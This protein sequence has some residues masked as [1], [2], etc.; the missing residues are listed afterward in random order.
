M[1]AKEKQIHILFIDDELN[2]QNAFF[3]GFR[4]RFKVYTASSAAEG[5]EVLEKEKIH[6]I[7]ADQRMPQFTGV[8]FFQKV[9]RSHPHP[10]RILL[11][12]Y[13]DIEALEDA[14]NKGEIYRY[15]KKPWDDKEVDQAI[16]NAYEIYFTREQL[17]IKITEL[18]KTN[19]EL[20]R[21][22]YSTSHDLRSPL[23]SIMGVL[24][25]AKMENSVKD[26]NGYMEMIG[27]CAVKMD[28]YIKKIIEYYR[29]VR[30][31]EANDSID[32]KK[33]IQENIQLH[34]MQ[35][36]AIRFDVS[37]TQDI[38]FV[39]DV[40]RV[41]VIFDNLISN[42]L[43]YQ[44]PEEKNQKISIEVRVTK[45]KAL[46]IIEDNGIGI[47]EKDLMNIFTMFFRSTSNATGLG[48]GLFIVQEAVS[49][50]HGQISVQSELGKGTKFLLEIPNKML[51]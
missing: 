23:A 50:L 42:A 10:M 32:F 20:N 27:I 45:E 39:N 49:K 22:V 41:T 15:I 31:E 1:L 13:T 2:N 8:Q 17:R 9:R 48:I 3:A 33:I 34:K 35:N 28:D 12:G 29:S 4:R 5:L 26:P 11:T 36:P 25:L 38:A 30:V 40:F 19:D 44:K 43:K 21:L 24:N 46:I 37:V 16:R 6:V 14:V 51:A 7:I 18:E 47:Q